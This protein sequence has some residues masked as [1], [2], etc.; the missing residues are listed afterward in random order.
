MQVE[1]THGLDPLNVPN[2]SKPLPRPAAAGPIDEAAR[3][4][5]ADA[6]ADAAVQPLAA[7]A[8]A[9]PEV[10]PDAVAEARRLIESGDLDTPEAARK[11]A[12]RL[13]DLGI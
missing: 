1:R 13:L 7:Q 9:A 11:A 12:E 2:G 8:A 6:P 10:R 3:P 4:E 5:A